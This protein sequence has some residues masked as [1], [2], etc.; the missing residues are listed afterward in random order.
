MSTDRD[1][2]AS[3]AEALKRAYA[4]AKARNLELTQ[5]KLAIQCGWKS[6]GS[7]QKYFSG[8]LELNIEAAAK[9]ARALD[10]K[11]EDFSPR[12]ATEL[13]EILP[14]TKNGANFNTG[15]SDGDQAQ[16][17]VAIFNGLPDQDVEEF[18]RLI[19]ERRERYKQQ[20]FSPEVANIVKAISGLDDDA[21]SLLTTTV[22]ALQKMQ[23]HKGQQK[24]A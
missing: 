2:I 16:G 19:D 7:V 3:E 10:C 11:I 8:V 5:E 21:L 18:I 9:L 13:F 17:S 22:E 1:V 24:A 20:Q 6:Q 23:T 15:N 12:I 14:L 4:E